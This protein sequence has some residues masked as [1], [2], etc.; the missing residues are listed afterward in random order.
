MID[1]ASLRIDLFD[2]VENN[3]DIRLVP[4]NRPDRLSDIARGQFGRG[5]LI[6]KRLEEMM[7][8]PVDQNDLYGRVRQRFRSAEAAESPSD[9]DNHR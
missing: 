5:Y 2:L 4:K 7:V 3:A 9:D 6:K 8:A 1:L